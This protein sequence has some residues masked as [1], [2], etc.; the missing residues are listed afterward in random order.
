MTGALGTAT[1][2]ACVFGAA[3]AAVPAPVVASPNAAITIATSM[4]S[5]CR[6]VIV[7]PAF[8]LSVVVT[9][10]SL[11]AAAGPPQ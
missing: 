5:R 4:E 9:P 2:A 6:C 1:A 10:I 8:G 7:P 3:A 11:D